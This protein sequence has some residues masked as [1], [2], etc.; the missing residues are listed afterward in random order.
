MSL[1]D[2]S[3]PGEAFPQVLAI[4]DGPDGSLWIGT[5]SRLI[6]RMP[7]G[8]VSSWAA[9]VRAL[10]FDREGKLWAGGA[11]GFLTL[12]FGRTPPTV[13][14][15]V[16]GLHPLGDIQSFYLDRTGGMWI[17]GFGLVRVQ[18]GANRPENRLRF[19]YFDRTS[20]LGSQYLFALSE[21]SAGNLWAALGNVGVV[22]ILRPDICGQFTEADGLESRSVLAVSETQDGSL[23]AVTGSRHTLNVFD[24]GRFSR[25]Q[26]RV[27]PEVTNFGSGENSIAVQDRR[28]EWW[29]ATSQ[30]LLHYPRVANFADLA[31]IMPRRYTTADGLPDNGITRLLEDSRG[32]MWIGTLSGVARW[33]AA[34][35]SIENLTPAL[36]RVLNRATIPH[37]FAEDAAGVVWAGFYQGGLVRWRDGHPESIH[38]GLPAGS[39]NSLLRDRN[40]RLWVASSQQGLASIDDPA[41]PSP[42]FQLYGDVLGLRSK[43][44]F[45]LAEDHSGRIYVAGGYG[46]DRLDPATRAVYHLSAGGGVLPSGETQRVLC[47]RQGV[48]WFASN[49]GLSRYVPEQDSI[50]PPPAPL[51]HEVRISGASRLTSDEGQAQVRG[52]NLPAG[53]EAIE[54]GYG[55]IDFSV[56]NNLRYRYRLSPGETQWRQPTAARSVQ[57]A[58]V[59]SG[60]YRFEVQAVGPSG[61]A[62]SGIATVEFQIAAP[63]WKSWWFLLL[64]GA[65]TAALVMA[66]HLYRVRTLLAL[67]RVRTR[68]AADLHD[69]LGAGLTEIAILTE[70][71]RQDGNRQD[72][73]VVAQR[74]R[75][76]RASMSDIVWSVD[77]EC[78]NLEE[79]IR[80]WRQTAFALLGNETVEFTAPEASEMN[81]IELTPDWRRQLLLFFKEAVTNV[82]RHASAE[83][84]WIEVQPSPGCLHLEVH[85]D[86]C[87]FVPERVTDG[88]GLKNMA[89]RAESLGGVLKVHSSP[90]EGTTVR[91]NVAMRLP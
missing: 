79:L 44:L 81:R 57:Y 22:R 9:H 32:D 31:T 54:I 41:A 40:G 14:R 53:R 82:A 10:L 56:G 46:V 85:D 47:D 90:G 77:P 11:G 28:G 50:I 45:A 26:P 75:E 12:D 83:R 69:D 78:D 65:S 27:P 52:L 64:A 60:A 62:S 16:F 38:E 80:R 59:G 86:G 70:V 66:A 76:L 24:G 58:G 13:D 21:D 71:A 72:L 33:S 42:H 7:D 19:Q 84:V 68:L 48:L 18:P 55:S 35:Q 17:G 91:L 25:I 74:A 63:F 30:G 39:I 89:A 6:R 3:H 87:G 29:M 2:A 23:Y 67:E 73:E 61:L 8:G 43:H 88:N 5:S 15:H 20:L 36:Q 4:L 51:I 34:T 49:F 1:P 37:S